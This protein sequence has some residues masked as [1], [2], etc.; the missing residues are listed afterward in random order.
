MGGIISVLSLACTCGAFLVNTSGSTMWLTIPGF[1]YARIGPQSFNLTAVA[2]IA[3]PIDTCGPLSRRYDGVIIVYALGSCN[4][5]S[6]VLSSQRAGAV[7]QIAF[8][9]GYSAEMIASLYTESDTPFE[10]VL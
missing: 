4:P 2:R 8:G 1:T 9:A 3:D 10:P 6:R 7:G 5:V